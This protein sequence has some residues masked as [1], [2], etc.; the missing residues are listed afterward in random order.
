[1]SLRI[2]AGRL[3]ALVG[4]S[5][6]GKSTLV[7]L[8]QRLYDPSGGAVLLG[9]RDLRWGGEGW[10]QGRVVGG[11]FG[12]GG[13]ASTKGL[14]LSLPSLP[15]LPPASLPILATATAA[16][17]PVGAGAWTRPGSGNG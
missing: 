6:S 11:G 3:T 8:V 12:G 5:G 9:G 15:S 1:M 16:V 14:P 7:A 4:L 13:W 10:G 2:P 17:A